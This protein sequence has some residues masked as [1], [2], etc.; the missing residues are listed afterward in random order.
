MCQL[1]QVDVP[2]GD[3]RL[4]LLHPYAVRHHGLITRSAAASLGISRDAWYRAIRSG[5]VEPLYP[6]VA[7]LWGAPPTFEQQILAA[8]L[9][10]GPGALASHRSSARLWGV[11][12][13]DDDP[14][15]LLLPPRKRWVDVPG[16]IVHRPRDARDLM[17]LMR[18]QVPTTNPMRML[19]DLGAVD[20][21]SVYPAAV[22]LLQ[23]RA[24]DL[25][26]LRGGL[27]RH[28]G[29][30][31][32]GVT[33]YRQMLDHLQEDGRPTDSEL[34]TRMVRLLRKYHLPPATFH[35]RVAGFEVDFLFENSNVIIECQGWR[36]HGLQRE[37]WVFDKRRDAVLL[38]H[39]YVTVY[40]TWSEVVHHPAEVAQRLLETLRRWAPHLLAA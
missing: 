38:S 31:R 35:A 6:N 27:M 3:M 4:E 36:F 22:E 7:R 39:G 13:P 19:L 32:H 11:R 12:R 9:A 40:A 2:S 28:V 10:A 16:V 25:P 30:G 20:P 33:A 17:P 29:R 14:I 23:A 18:S 24:V 21:A 15:E 5:L 26:A 34:E 1:R 8:V 37:Q